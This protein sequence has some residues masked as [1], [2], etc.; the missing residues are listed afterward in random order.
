MELKLID[1]MDILELSEK[2]VKKLI[3][4]KN[5]PFYKI[6]NEYKFNKAEIYNWILKNNIKFSN[7]VLD[8]SLTNKPVIM[9]DLIKKGG[10]FYQI[11]GNSIGET[12]ANSV[13]SINTPKE[14]SKEKIITSLLEREEMMPTS[15]GNGIAIPHSRN[16]IITDVNNESISLCFLKEKIDFN[17]IDG[18]YV[19]TLF[20]LLSANPKRHLEILSK[21]AYLCQQNDFMSLLKN[22]SQKNE[23]LKYVESF[24]LTIKTHNTSSS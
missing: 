16:P 12:I 3:K 9:I 17:A 6:R 11:K 2:Q 8:L 20:I 10:I 14:I 21:I 7:K 13:N 24:D 22:K 18:I 23:I 4:E 19:D 1:L 15:V 5:L